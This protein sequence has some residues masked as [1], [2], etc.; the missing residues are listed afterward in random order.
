[1]KYLNIHRKYNETM[2]QMF[3]IETNTVLFG[4]VIVAS[5]SPT[6]KAGG[7]EESNVCEDPPEKLSNSKFYLYEMNVDMIADPANSDYLE[8]YVDLDFKK[9]P[10]KN[11]TS[12]SYCFRFEFL[13]LNYQCL[14][15][16]GYP[17]VKVNFP[18]PSKDYGFVYFL[19]H[20]FIFTLPKHVH[21]YPKEWYHMCVSHELKSNQKMIK[22]YF[23][24]H[25][26]IDATRSTTKKL[27]KF[28]DKWT[29]GFCKYY[30]FDGHTVLSP[31]TT[32][33][34]GAISDFN[35]WS[36]VLND[37]E[38]IAFTK[39]C[40]RPGLPLLPA[41]DLI[42]WDDMKH[43]DHA[44]CDEYENDDD[45]ED[46]HGGGGGIAVPGGHKRKRRGAACVSSPESTCVSVGDAV[47]MMSLTWVCQKRSVSTLIFETNTIF[48]DAMS[49]CN[50]LGGEIPI[51]KTQNETIALSKMLSKAIRGK[52][53]C[54]HFWIP[55]VQR[56]KPAR[57]DAHGVTTDHDTGH[58]SG[59]GGHKRKRRGASETATDDDTYKVK[60]L[61]DGQYQPFIWAEYF[62]DKMTP[63]ESL[64]WDAGQPDGWTFQ[65]CVTL[66][67]HTYKYHDQSCAE[68]TFCGFCQFKEPVHY[69]LRGVK[70]EYPWDQEYVF[71]P[72]GFLRGSYA[73]ELTGYHNQVIKLHPP[74]YGADDHGDED[75]HDD[76]DADDQGDNGH[77]DE[78]DESNEDEHED[79]TGDSDDHSDDDNSGGGGGGIAVPGGGDGIV[80]PGGRRKRGSKEATSVVH[81]RIRR[82]ASSTA[83]AGTTIN[84]WEIVDSQKGIIGILEQPPTIKISPMGKRTWIP[85]MDGTQ[86][87]SYKKEL[88]L[89]KVLM[90]VY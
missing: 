20:A 43:M 90:I 18:E 66:D 45:D 22:A 37:N 87:T 57:E 47:H 26:I 7:D 52:Y 54:E 51:P 3:F 21:I 73:V 75:E 84:T 60:N 77:G 70:K 35:L 1:M 5:L 53:A 71:V 28:N 29:L 56:D 25:K 79:E 55:I 83:A 12:F 19:G 2:R 23:N 68:P 30:K 13:S 63:A 4:I 86:M 62:G 10:P 72:Q 38:M 8:S 89:T 41:A 44:H 14:F 39:T 59:S 9:T 32:I 48:Y 85:V 76:D 6:S 64:D 31:L 69:Y 88:K 34:R 49:W 81:K 65:P 58:G 46:S 80:V 27:V 40:T 16:E 50:Q 24:G 74:D 82:G 36:K 17:N 15:Y 67:I 33:T 61:I 42:N 11:L 78:H